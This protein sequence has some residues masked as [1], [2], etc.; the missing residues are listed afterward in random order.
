MG[1][2]RRRGAGPQCREL[3]EQDEGGGEGLE[4]QAVAWSRSVPRNSNVL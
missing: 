2:R 4:G 3:L 1:Q